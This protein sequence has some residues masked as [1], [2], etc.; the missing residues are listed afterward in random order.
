MQRKKSLYMIISLFI[1]F[2]LCIKFLCCFFYFKNF[3]F[4]F[5]KLP[6]FSLNTVLIRRLLPRF[7]SQWKRAVLCRVP[8][9]FAYL[10]HSM[11]LSC[12]RVI[13][14]RLLFICLF[15]YFVYYVDPGVYLVRILL[16]KTFFLYALQLLLLLTLWNCD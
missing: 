16:N 3:V 10:T 4:P 1:S 15:I 7:L 13:R 2:F 14:S 9:F 11:P 12:W 5:W 8:V 6:A